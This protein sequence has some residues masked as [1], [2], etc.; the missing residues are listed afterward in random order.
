VT[1]EQTI[2]T[3]T[4]GVLELAKQRGNVSHACQIMG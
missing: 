4:V 1:T 3:T 2:I